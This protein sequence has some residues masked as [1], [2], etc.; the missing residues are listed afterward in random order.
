MFG[1]AVLLPVAPLGAVVGTVPVELVGVVV[2]AVVGTVAVEEPVAAFASTAPPP[3]SAPVT[4]R[5]ASAIC[6]RLC[7]FMFGDSFGLGED[8]LS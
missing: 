3:A 8:N 7:L 6:K 5:V 4:T 1:H 2:V